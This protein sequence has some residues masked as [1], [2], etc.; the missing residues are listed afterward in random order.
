[1]AE[2][3]I[4]KDYKSLYISFDTIEDCN[5][6]SEQIAKLVEKNSEYSI[7]KEFED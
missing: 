6:F 7:K 5:W 3:V 4:Y 1:M 2:L